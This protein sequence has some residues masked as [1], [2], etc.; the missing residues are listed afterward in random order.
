MLKMAK[1]LLLGMT[2]A[3]LLL[4]TGAA[5]QSAS[6]DP[7]I[8]ALSEMVFHLSASGG[9]RYSKVI[10]LKAALEN[11][12]LRTFKPQTCDIEAQDAAC[13]ESY[14][15]QLVMKPPPLCWK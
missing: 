5:Q 6:R 13:H 3:C 1:N 15:L 9:K 11:P 8:D 12:K 2:L 14:W 4:A 10:D 7:E